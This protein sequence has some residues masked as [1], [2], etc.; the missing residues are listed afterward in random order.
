MWIRSQ[1]KEMLAKVDVLYI[2]KGKEYSDIKD[3]YDIVDDKYRYG[4][5]KTI[6]RAKEVLSDIQKYI[7]SDIMI[8]LDVYEMPKE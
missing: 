6:E 8:N 2:E 7:N 5:Y 4:R 1:N 3:G